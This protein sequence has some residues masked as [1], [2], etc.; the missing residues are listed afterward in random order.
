FA[1]LPFCGYNMG[2]YFAHW[3]KIGKD[4]DNSKLPKIFYVNWFRKDSDGNFIWPGFGENIRAIKWAIERIEGKENYIETPIGRL[5]DI[6]QFD[7]SGLNLDKEDL[8]ELFTVDKERG[9]QELEEMREY[10][11]IFGD[12]LP[13]ELL[14]EIDAQEKRFRE[15]G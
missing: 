3:I 9:L 15:M 5:P 7:L 8:K 14:D 12:R 4:H 13:K 2:D 10:F 1:M 11:K 6:N